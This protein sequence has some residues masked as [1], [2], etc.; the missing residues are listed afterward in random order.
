MQATDV[1]GNT[2]N[3]LLWRPDDYVDAFPTVQLR[4][5]FTPRL[6][7]RATYSTGIARPGF[8]QNTTAVSVDFSQSPV[9][10]T[11]GNPDLKP[12]FG[13]NFDLSLEYYMPGGGILSAALFD[14]EFQHYITPSLVNGTTADPISQGQLA[15]V[16]TYVNIP[17]AYARGVQLDFHQKFTG[18]P[19]PFEGFGVDGNLTLVESRALEYTAVQTGT[20]NEYGLLPGTSPV[21]WNLAGF[22]EDHGVQ[23]R[24]AA[25]YVGHS[26][27]GLSGDGNL[28]A[29]FVGQAYDTYQDKRLTMDLTSSYRVNRTWTVYF[30]AKNLL[31]T[32]LRYYEGAP[33]R[34][35]QREF[36]D[37]T[38]EG[39]VRAHF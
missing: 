37:I 23:V 2:T 31:N 21:T 17:S 16:T 7:A 9:A 32:P 5:E 3:S 19:A 15:I 28:N 36:Y 34:P 4:Y 30:N 8:T 11:E 22:Y 25:E 27:F 35:I 18:L 26:L 38:L 33:D 39:G 6:I 14:K 13:Q 10:V 29:G 24:L 20:V 12:T 1:N